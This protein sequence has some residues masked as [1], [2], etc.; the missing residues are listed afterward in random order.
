MC[1]CVEK[2]RCCGGARQPRAISPACLA[3]LPPVNVFEATVEVNCLDVDEGVNCSVKAKS[4]KAGSVSKRAVAGS[5]LTR[6]EL[7]V[8]NQRRGLYR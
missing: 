7:S 6:R 5:S 4:N 1:V 8:C 3:C 2:G